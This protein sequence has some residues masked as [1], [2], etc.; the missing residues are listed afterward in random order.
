MMNGRY[1]AAAA[2][3]LCMAAPLAAQERVSQR[4]AAQGS[5][6]VEISNTAGSVSVT[7]WDRDEVEVTGTLGRGTERL[8]LDNEAGRTVVRVVLPRYGRSEGSEIQV[9]V[10]ARR[11][12][13]VRTVSADAEVRGV[14]AFVDVRTV[15]GEVRVDGQPREVSA[16]SRSG[17]VT[18]SATTARVKAESV[19]GEVRV[20]GDVRDRVEASTVSGDLSVEAR[21]PE[22]HVETVSG[23]VVIGALS[24]RAEVNTVSGDVR[25]AGHRIQADVRSVSGDVSIEGDLDGQAATQINTHSG[26]VRL[27]LA[28]GAGAEL[29]FSSFS[30]DVDGDVPGGMRMTRSG[31]HEQHFV[32]GR[33]GARVV[34][35]TFSGDLAVQ[36]S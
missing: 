10:P 23:D 4:V 35:H 29:D 28:R 1:L 14:T 19:S 5:G 33:G 12:V 21:T 9:R 36:G 3:A 27:S 22:A 32:V 16:S 25:L 24:G 17:S 11:D 31:A 20:A 13:V 34:V 30:G 7:A 6:P 18:V 15:S 8:Q 26:D 2:A